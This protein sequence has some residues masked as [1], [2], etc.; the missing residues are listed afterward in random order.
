MSGLL[1]AATSR[2]KDCLLF[3]LEFTGADQGTAHIAD[4][5]SQQR[6][7]SLRCMTWADQHDPAV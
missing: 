2:A 1:F 6:V 7:R 4:G 3:S 5:A